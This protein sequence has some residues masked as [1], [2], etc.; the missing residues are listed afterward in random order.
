MVILIWLVVWDIF[1][2]PIYWECH[3][4]N[5]LWYFSEGW[6]N[7]QPVMI[8]IGLRRINIWRHSI[9]TSGGFLVLQQTSPVEKVAPEK[10]RLKWLNQLGGELP[11]FIVFVG[12]PTL[13]INYGISGAMSTCNWGEL[14][15]LRFVGWTTKKDF[16]LEYL[17]YINRDISW[18]ISAGLFQPFSA[19]GCLL[20]I[21]EMKTV[22]WTPVDVGDY[23]KVSVSSWGYPQSS[24]ILDWEFPV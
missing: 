23:L 4:P 14:T 10:S 19:L 12:E 16:F 24:S 18:D 6:P 13:V 20:G 15:H 2:F 21:R 7:H 5:W 9:M 1:Y 3:D 8:M 17:C 22:S 11:T